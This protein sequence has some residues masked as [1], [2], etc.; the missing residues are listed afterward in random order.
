MGKIAISF[1]W[2]T[3]SAL[4]SGLFTSINTPTEEAVLLS[5]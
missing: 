2:L 1:F 4:F 3:I 5:L